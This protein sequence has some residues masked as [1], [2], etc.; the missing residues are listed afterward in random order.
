MGDSPRAIVWGAGSWGTALAVHLAASGHETALWV[1]EGDLFPRMDAARENEVFLPG[2][3][4]PE[5]LTLFNDPAKP[6]FDAP[7]WISVIPTQHLRPLWEKIGPTCPSGTTVVSASKGIERA[8]HLRPSEILEQCLP[9]PCCPVVVV[10]GPSFATDL[11]KGDP[12]AVVFAAPDPARASQAQRLFSHLNFRGYVSTDRTGVELGGAMKNVMALACGVTVGLG[13]GS[14]AVAAIITR[15]L[16]EM[17]RLGTAMGAQAETFSGLSGLGDLVLT[18]TGGESRNR[19]V[20]IRLGQGETLTTVLGSMKM[21]AE[22]VPTTRSVAE[23]GREKGVDLPITFIMERI[24]FEEL[25][26]RL[27]LKELLSRELKAENL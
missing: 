23:L 4:F 21:V 14:N 1:Y 22:G 25:S 10:S 15:G 17:I 5:G 18:C 19:A 20:G 12:T 11:S 27:A 3:H 9:K 16:R 13:F 24:L 2:I 7:F 8:S 6:P 26:P